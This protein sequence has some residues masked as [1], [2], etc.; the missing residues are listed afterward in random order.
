MWLDA[1][2][3]YLHLLAILSWV[4]FLS[5]TAAL[6]R[7]EWLNAAVVAR[8]VVVDRIAFGAGWLVLASGAARLL[9][10][11]KGA[12]WWLDQ[13]LLWAKIALVVLMLMAAWRTHGQIA[14][15]HR[16]AAASGDARVAL[17]A[18]AAGG[19]SA[20]GAGLVDSLSS[21]PTL[22]GDP[23]LTGGWGHAADLGIVSKMRRPSQ[24]EQGRGRRLQRPRGSS[25]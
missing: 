17:D 19:G 20:A 21:R 22:H 23:L 15:W 7:V 4:V 2:L 1:G 5:S 14:G 6:A 11:A 3:S 18:G 8:L 10:G 16:R 24:S 9:W 12:A 13:P 25:T